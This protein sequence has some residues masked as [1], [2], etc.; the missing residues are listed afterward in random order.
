MNKEDLYSHLEDC[1]TEYGINASDVKKCLDEFFDSNICIPKGANR[2][3]YADV[4]HKWI[5][6]TEMEV[7]QKLM[8]YNQHSNMPTV[9]KVFKYE[10][11]IKPS[12]PIYEWQ[13]YK[14][15]NGHID[16]THTWEVKQYFT[17]DEK[18]TTDGWIKFEETKR[19]R[20]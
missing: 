6:G 20:R 10:Y 2:H 9:T 3:P 11:R 14:F 5:E 13:W 12:E 8:G 4:L 15:V 7:N 16:S 17:E 18:Y 1:E 19:I